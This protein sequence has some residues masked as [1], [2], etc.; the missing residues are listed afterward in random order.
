[1]AASDIGESNH[2][3]P[4]FIDGN[5]QRFRHVI[6]YMRYRKVELPEHVGKESFL[7]DLDYYGFD[8]VDPN[9]IENLLEK[10]KRNERMSLLAA[11]CRL[12]IGCNLSFAVAE[13]DEEK[14]GLSILLDAEHEEWHLYHLALVSKLDK[15]NVRVA[16][17]GFCLIITAVGDDTRRFLRISSLR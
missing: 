3:S 16:Y 15:Q 7:T 4:I 9:Q 11:K 10:T 2:N 12:M 5:E 1:M 13:S 8:R 14:I 17:G 6:D